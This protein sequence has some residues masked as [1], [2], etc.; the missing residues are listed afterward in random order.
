MYLNTYTKQI[1]SYRNPA[2]INSSLQ[3]VFLPNYVAFFLSQ[4]KKKK[5]KKKGYQYVVGGDDRK[6]HTKVD[7]T[8]KLKVDSTIKLTPR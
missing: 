1:L 3:H 5:K 8:I 6:G 7:S 4:K 2:T